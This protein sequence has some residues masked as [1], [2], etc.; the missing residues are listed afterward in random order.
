MHTVPLFDGWFSPRCAFVL[1]LCWCACPCTVPRH[2]HHRHRD[3][4]HRGRPS[5]LRWKVHAR[6]ITHTHTEL[7]ASTALRRPRRLAQRHHSRWRRQQRR[8]RHKVRKCDG[9]ARPA[10]AVRSRGGARA[11]LVG[12]EGRA[13][14]RILIT[15][16][17]PC[18][19]R[20]RR[21]CADRTR[22]DWVREV[23]E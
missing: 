12:W 10:D 14:G 17:E 3:N 8:R 7:F 9:R 19:N 5:T 4:R 6:T 23:H 15:S 16:S 2:N 11:Q 20:L 13:M 18:Q 22:F 21:Q 1:V